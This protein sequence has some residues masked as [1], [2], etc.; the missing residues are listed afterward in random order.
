[1]DVGNPHP[2]A[3]L[4]AFLF[5]LFCVYY[6]SADLFRPR[7]NRIAI[8]SAIFAFLFL[9]AGG[10]AFNFLYRKNFCYA[11]LSIPPSKIKGPPYRIGFHV[12]YNKPVKNVAV[13]F[14]DVSGTPSGTELD[15]R[16]KEGKSTFFP[17]IY[18]TV[19][20]ET[21]KEVDCTGEKLFLIS[22]STEVGN[23][24]EQLICK[25]DDIE[26]E[27]IHIT[28]VRENGTIEQILYDWKPYQKRE[29]SRILEWFL[30][31]VD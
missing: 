6:V 27:T 26:N 20:V 18:P 17:I 9:I 12:S 31:L 29:K 14:V 25:N 30:D 23:F 8:Q 10:K 21:N 5:L 3:A 22:M 4:I 1:M 13:G 15:K 11:D 19:G 28:R 2:Y 7:L 24:D 16:V